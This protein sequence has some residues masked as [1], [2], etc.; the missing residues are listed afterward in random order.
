MRVVAMPYPPEA[1]ILDG[2]G[3]RHSAYEL[4]VTN[5][6]KTPLKITKLDV[7]GKDDDKVVVNQS[8]SGKQLAAMFVPA[9]RR[10]HQAQRSEPQAGRDRRL[11][12]LCRLASRPGRSRQFRY[13]D[14]DRAARRAQ[15][16]RNNSRRRARSESGR[17]DRDSFSASRQK[18]A[19]GQRLLRTRR[20]IAAR[21]CR[22]TVSRTS[23]SAMRSTGFSSAT[24]ARRLPATS[25]TT[26]AITHGIRRFTRSPTARSSR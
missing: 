8:A 7:N 3:H 12:Y 14:Y 17:S 22:L 13:C 21:C 5:W 19:R 11:L 1:Q 2:A 10:R 9:E 20:R 26:G 23:A 15:R 18:L 6:G 25:T 16:L 24:T 4:Y